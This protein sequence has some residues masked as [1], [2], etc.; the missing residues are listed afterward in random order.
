MTQTTCRVAAMAIR[1]IA[2]FSM[3]FA[4]LLGMG[5][6]L[7]SAKAEPAK[8]ASRLVAQL[9]EAYRWETQQD[10]PAHAVRLERATQT[11]L[12]KYFS[13]ELVKALMEDRAC[14]EASA[15]G[16]C[17]LDFALLW[18]SQDPTG[19]KALPA[20]SIDTDCQCVK[21]ILLNASGLPHGQL[22]YRFKLTPKG[23]RIN[24]IEYGQ[25]GRTLLTMLRAFRL[26]SASNPGH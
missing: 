26:E 5:M 24:D 12:K 18:D 13:D 10:W 19:M 8:G 16:P 22:S 20:A 17:A 11:R 4:I 23:L 2:K 7:A 1:R 3:A 25:E 6:H 14:S 9:Y 15:G 21:V